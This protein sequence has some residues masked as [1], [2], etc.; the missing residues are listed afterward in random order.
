MEGL[1][2]LLYLD[3]VFGLK[4]MHYFLTDGLFIGDG[5]GSGYDFLIFY[6]LRVF[7]VAG[8]DRVD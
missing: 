6:L 4:N 1:F 3:G 8:V 5:R 2:G 7:V